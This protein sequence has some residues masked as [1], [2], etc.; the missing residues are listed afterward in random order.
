[1]PRIS[2]GLRAEIITQKSPKF[3]LPVARLAK[4]TAAHHLDGRLNF[5]RV[6]T[7]ANGNSRQSPVLCSECFMPERRTLQAAAYGY[8]E[9][10][11]CGGDRGTRLLVDGE[12]ERRHAL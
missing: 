5:T 12:R 6:L 11:E 9:R 1:M 8:A 3:P 2:G 10:L 7:D 4:D